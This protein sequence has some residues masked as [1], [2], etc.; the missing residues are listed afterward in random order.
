MS[1]NSQPVDIEF[2][3]HLADIIADGAVGEIEIK[4]D[5]LRIRLSRESGGKGSVTMMAP[6]SYAAPPAAPA[7]AS[8]SQT[9]AAP[10]PPAS[11]D[12]TDSGSEG[13][14]VPSP[15]VGTAYVASAPGAEPYIRVG[16]TVS[17]GQTIM[18]VEAMKTMNQIPSPRDGTVKSIC[19]ED[20]QPVEYGEP[21][22]TLD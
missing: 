21:L 8:M 7:P 14:P 1:D 20:G 15:M 11:D 12:D 13:D 18:I 19:V 3:R 16:D 2:I 5:D 10:A 17:K 6:S 22:I 9:G 4:Q